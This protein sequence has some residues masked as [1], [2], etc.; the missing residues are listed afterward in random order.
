VEF[1]LHLNFN[2]KLNLKWNRNNPKEKE[3]GK[4]RDL[5]SRLVLPTGTKGPHLSWLA[6]PGQKG[7]LLSHLG[8][9]GWEIG[10]KDLSQPGQKAYSVA[11]S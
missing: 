9:P 3:K 2:T 6:D 4:K 10:I 7:T 1:I 11:V 8:G 5:C